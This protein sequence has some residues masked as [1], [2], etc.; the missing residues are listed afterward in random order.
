MRFEDGINDATR[1]F[2]GVEH[3]P[4]NWNSYYCDIFN[5][6]GILSI[7][8]TDSAMPA[9]SV[10]FAPLY[11]T[12]DPP[13]GAWAGTYSGTATVGGCPDTNPVGPVNGGFNIIIQSGVI[14]GDWI[15]V[16]K[17]PSEPAVIGAVA[18][19]VI[20]FERNFIGP[21]YLGYS[22]TGTINGLQANG[23]WSTVI[24]LGGCMSIGSGTWSAHSV[25]Q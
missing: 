15:I 4:N 14:T 20:T 3:M 21:P 2:F 9:N 24:G 1:I 19:N 10:D 8:L 23:T 22:F 6:G 11:L 13:P 16:G 17:S 7:T 5:R 12:I 18:G 25:L